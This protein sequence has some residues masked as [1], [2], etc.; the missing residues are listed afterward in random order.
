MAS[1]STMGG[2]GSANSEMVQRAVMSNLNNSMIGLMSPSGIGLNQTIYAHEES[3]TLD[4]S[5]I[6]VN[7]GI[8][9]IPGSSLNLGSNINFTILNRSTISGLYL[10][11]SITIPQNAVL[12]SKWFY[13]AVQ[14]IQ[15]NIPGT[16]SYQLN[17]V[18]LLDLYMR[19]NPQD[20]RDGL[21]DLIPSAIGATGGTN[22]PFTVPLSYIIGEGWT[23]NDGFYMSAASLANVIQISFQFEPAYRWIGALPA[24]IVGSLPTQFNSLTLKLASQVDILNQEFDMA[25]MSDIFR[26]PFTYITSNP[27]FNQ[28]NSG[29]SSIQTLNLTALPSGELI[30]IFIHAIPSNKVGVS[31]LNRAVNFNP[32]KFDYHKLSLQGTDLILL[33]N[34][35]EILSQNTFY[36]VGDSCGFYYNDNNVTS[37]YVGGTGTFVY[38]GSTIV[39]AQ[40]RFTTLECFIADPSS[41][42]NGSKFQLSRNFSG[43]VLTFYYV[44]PQELTNANCPYI[45]FYVTYISNGIVDVQKGT[46]T[47]IT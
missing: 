1:A 22:V 19:Q 5:I 31:A 35:K 27:I 33:E 9:R 18:S 13:Y 11:G 38:T 2:V 10:T 41:C 12:P 14:N 17:G 26:I 28:V 46:S 36:S 47:L 15:F 42:F 21:N 16:S 4:T 44:V 3:S 43:Q 34:E 37:A 24:G 39:S 45:D 8:A 25:K 32:I 6:S 7:S 40:Q 30:S 23:A 29:P 20:R